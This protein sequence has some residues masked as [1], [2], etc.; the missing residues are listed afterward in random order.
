MQLKNMHST[1]TTAKHTCQLRHIFII[2]SSEKLIKTYLV[3]IVVLSR[4]VRFS[5]F[6][7][8]EVYCVY[9]PGVAFFCL[10]LV[11]ADPKIQG[12]IE[13]VRIDLILFAIFSFGSLRSC[14]YYNGVLL[15][16]HNGYPNYR[17]PMGRLRVY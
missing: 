3:L 13:P 4:S 1:A 12:L 8:P 17:H 11:M 6:L 9:S 16:V 2:N 14:N 10:N 5:S 7:C 15:Y